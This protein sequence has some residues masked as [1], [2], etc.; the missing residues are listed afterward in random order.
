M[1][2]GGAIARGERRGKVV[3]GPLALADMHQRANH[4]AHLVL[5]ERTR[6]CGD[7][8]LLTGARDIEA[9]ERL[10]RRLGLALGGA[11][12]R[13]IVTADQPLRGRMHRF[14]V[15]RA[16]HVPRAIL[17]ER[18]VGAPIG[19]AVKIMPSDGGESR[20]EVRR[21]GFGAQD[22]DALRSQMEIDRV[23]D[24]FAVP[25]S[26]EIDMRDLAKRMHTGIGASGAIDGDALASERG[27]RLGKNGLHRN[28]VILRLPADEWRTVIFD[29]ELIT[30][31]CRV[32]GRR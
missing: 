5:E 6:R 4:G 24:G 20:V 7:A 16:R 8:D 19:N 28:S 14:G 22:G 23:A 27:D 1:P 30:G 18:Q 15:E 17:I 3:G 9:I 26:G 21:G 25:V 10:D 13:E 29:G 32:S 31:H 12:R 2:A 11:K